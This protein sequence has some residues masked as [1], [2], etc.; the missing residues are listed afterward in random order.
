MVSGKLMEM[1]CCYNEVFLTWS[2]GMIRMSIRRKAGCGL[3]SDSGSE[4]T[5]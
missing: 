5:P 2:I 3:S 4:H 1:V